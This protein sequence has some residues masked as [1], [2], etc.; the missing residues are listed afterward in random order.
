[1]QNTTIC[2]SCGGIVELEYNYPNDNYEGICPY[3]GLYVDED[4]LEIYETIE[5][6]DYHYGKDSIYS[7]FA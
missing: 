3:C 7:L 5:V 6:I 1:M 2:D 4:G